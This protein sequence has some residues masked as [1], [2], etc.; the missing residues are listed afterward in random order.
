MAAI[1]RIAAGEQVMIELTQEAIDVNAVLRAVGSPSSGAIVLFLGTVR[2]QTGSRRTRSLT[3]E[4]FA[5]MASRALADLEA[6]ATR[7]WSLCRCAIVHRLGELAVGEI[8]VAIAASAAH[9]EAAF[10]ASR[11]LIDRIK[12]VVPIWKQEHWEDGASEWV[13][14][15]TDVPTAA[16]DS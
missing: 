15:G 12:Q 9:R 10:E 1:G 7:R 16:E 13:H 14:P 8:S 6:E 2:E 5:E 3:Y 4:A 11:W